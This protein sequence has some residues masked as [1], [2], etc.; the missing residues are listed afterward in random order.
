[1]KKILYIL[2]LMIGCGNFY[3]C[4]DM[5]TADVKSSIDD[6]VIFTTPILAEG[7]LYGIINCFMET[8]SYRARYLQFYGANTDTELMLSN[9][10]TPEHANAQLASYS[11]SPSNS[12]MSVYNG[13]WAM[14]YQAIERANLMIEGMRTYSDLEND[15]E[16]RQ[17]YGE[18]LTIRAVFYA[19]LLKAWGDIPARFEPITNETMYIAKSD[20]DVIY[21]QLIEDLGEA[22]EYVAWPNETT[23]T[24]TVERFNKAFVKALRARLCLAAAGYGQRPD[25]TIR[26]SNDP[27]LT[28]EKMYTIARDECLDII[29]S[30]TC[31]LGGFEQTF[32][33]ISGE[34]ITAGRESLWE[35]PFA[36]GRGRVAYAYAIRHR[37]TSQY[38]NIAA[39]GSM[40]PM[41][42]LYYDYDPKDLRRDI[43]CIPYEWA[44]NSSLSIGVSQSVLNIDTWYY[45]KYRY[46]WMNRVASGDSDDGLNWLY[47]RYADV[48]LMAAETINELSGPDAAV[49]YFRPIRSRAFSEADQAEKVD[50]YIAE[51]SVSKE[52]FFEAIVD[53]R[54]FEFTG[55]ML[56]KQDLIRWNKLGEYIYAAR[57]KMEQ[58]AV[59]EG[60]YE[61][62]PNYLYYKIIDESTGEIDIYG[63]EIGDTDEYGAQLVE[64]EGYTRAS[65]QRFTTDGNPRIDE[66]KIYSITHNNPDDYQFWPIF[67]YFINTSNGMLVNDYNY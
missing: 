5:L 54:A 40:G 24:S 52:R 33:E 8:N 4:D 58:L 50:Q 16:L 14:M 22:A 10:T 62:L 13:P 45:G 44:A 35:I 20:R 1:M 9:A 32:R 31:T 23:V 65:S 42:T 64:N 2:V 61:D 51:V 27:D 63:L 39:G 19:D 15:P 49:E 7:V 48:Y 25:G 36:P 59:R 38:T 30:E 66:D 47:M 55:E 12:N 53:E 67:E 18:A 37:V 6:E 56:R 60:K 28:V 11:A 46:E 29:N 43:T 34:V 41:P 57:D 3:S 26:R 21:K 17:L